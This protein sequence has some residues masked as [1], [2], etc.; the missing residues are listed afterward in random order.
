MSGY[1]EARD[2][3]DILFARLEREEPPAGL[4]GRV[5]TRVAGRARTRRR[6]G[7]VAT[8]LALVAAAVV[9]F[10]FGAELRT[11]GGLAL[12]QT[13]VSDLE[14]LAEAPDDVALAV[15]DSVPWLLAALVVMSLVVLGVGARL[16]RMATV[17]PGARGW[18]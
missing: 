4:E 17:G 18:R 3:I 11:A 6:I 15:V 5:R 10:L 14:L 16:A 1:P 9:S 7:T 12:I 13:V 8:I 2:E